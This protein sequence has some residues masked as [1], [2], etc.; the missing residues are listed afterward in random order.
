MR[1]FINWDILQRIE[2]SPKEFIVQRN[3]ALLD[4]FLF[5]YEDFLLQLEHEEQLKA[6]YDTVLSLDEYARK[7]YSAD[8]IGTRNFKSIIA[9]TCEDERDF[10]GKYFDFLKEYEQK[11][12]VQETVSYILRETNCELKKLLTGMKNRYPMYFG[13]YD[14][15]YFRAFLDGYFLCKQEFNVPLTTFDTKVRKFTESIICKS[16]NITGDSVT[17]DRLYRYDRDWSAW[18]KTNETT[19]KEILEE[20]WKELEKFTGETIE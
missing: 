15:S 14:I 1:S 6:K 4:A 18:G 8:N 11:Y 10:F 16:L 5:G 17:W 2:N 3:V 12:P 9:F 7:K 20:F 13:N 19:E